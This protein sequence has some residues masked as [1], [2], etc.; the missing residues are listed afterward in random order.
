VTPEPNFLLQFL[1]AAAFL[2]N[3]AIGITALLAS[4]R[5]QPRIVEF[6]N[7]YATQ[8]AFDLEIGKLQRQISDLNVDLDSIR[9]EMKNDRNEILAAGE[10]RA[11][12]IHER[13]NI[14]GQHLSE[15][16]GELKGELKRMP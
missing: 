9:S 2:V 8:A 13:I 12:K 11:V 15:C 4:W 1:I 7:V 10:Q 16:I 14:L 3:L 6:A 5:K